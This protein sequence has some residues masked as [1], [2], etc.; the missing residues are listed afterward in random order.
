M[1]PRGATVD[2]IANARLTGADRL[3]P[4]GDDPVDIHLA[5]G[6]IVD[7]APVRA[8]P[9]RGEVLDAD[10]GWVIPGLWD[11]H[12]HTVQW[13]LVAQRVALG[14]SDRPQRPPL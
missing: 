11:H 1:P 10:G 8:L 13:A 6:R 5:Q 14:G 2:V 7:I 4:F 9:R 3:D 12:V